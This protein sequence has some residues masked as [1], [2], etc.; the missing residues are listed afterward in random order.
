MAR[1]RGSFSRDE[2]D[3]LCWSA[4]RHVER[5]TESYK[6]CFNEKPKKRKEP[7]HPDTRPELDDSDLCSPE[8][9][10]K[11]QRML[12]ALQWTMTLCRFDVAGAA[13]TLNTFSCSPRQNHLKW[14]KQIAEHVITTPSYG[15]RFRTLMRDCSHLEKD[16]ARFDWEHTVHGKVS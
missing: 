9:H 11:F 4:E 8:E 2:D 14:V 7:M 3:A 10:T 1:S 16:I 5:L 15:M 6:V 12:G 13:L